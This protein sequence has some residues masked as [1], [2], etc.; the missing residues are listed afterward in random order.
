M[1][2][3]S[4]ICANKCTVNKMNGRSTCFK[5]SDFFSF[6]GKVE[7]FICISEYNEPS[8]AFI[9]DCCW[10]QRREES[11]NRSKNS[12][13][14]H[15]IAR[16]LDFIPFTECRFYVRSSF[17][18]LCPVL[19]FVSPCVFSSTVRFSHRSLNAKITLTQNFYNFEKA[20]AIHLFRIAI[21]V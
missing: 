9:S 21:V 18:F 17:L 13:P 20:A 7:H 1:V 5:F 16:K 11:V 6:L 8:H 4:R 19:F 3:R 14:N 12:L 15:T 10:V 2:S